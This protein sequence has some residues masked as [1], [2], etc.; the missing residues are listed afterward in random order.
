MSK[1][2]VACCKLP[3]IQ[4]DY[5]PRGQYVELDGVKTYLAGASGADKAIFVVY[6][7]F[8]FFNQTLQ[9]ADILA[10]GDTEG[11]YQ[12]YVPDFFEGQPAS[13]DWY[14]PDTQEKVRFS[15]NSLGI[16][17]SNYK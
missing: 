8:G 16:N 12:V 5:Q 6:D 9:G 7:I 10:D 2:S 17:C 13:I 4:N 1:K 15:T 3:V 11:K 14:P